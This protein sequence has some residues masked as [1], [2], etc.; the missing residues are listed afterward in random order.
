MAGLTS[1]FRWLL[2]LTL[3]AALVGGGLILRD[4]R[5]LVTQDPPLTAAERTWA[6]RWLASA[7]PR[8]LR[9]GERV[10]LTLSEREANILGNYLIDT[11]GQGRL[12]VQLWSGRARLAVSLG[13]PWNPTTQFM[14]L[15][16]ELVAGGRRPRIERA[17]LAGLPMPDG[18]AQTLADRLIDALDQSRLLQRV[19]LQPDLALLTYEWRRDALVKLGTALV[20]VDEL[21]RILHYQSRLVGYGDAHPKPRTIALADLL[22]L[23]LAEA[24]RQA[25][26]A[27]PAENRAAILALAAYVNHQRVRDPAKPADATPDPAFRSVAL[28]GR[29]DLAQHFMTSATLAAQGGSA[30]SDLLGLY[31]EVSDSRGGSGF[32]FADLAA[33]R[34]GTRFGELATGEIKDA[35]AVQ[36]RARN[37]LREADIMPPIERTARGDERDGLRRRLSRHKK[38]KLPA[39]R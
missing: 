11:L 27:A 3:L 7:K 2:A 9:D 19:D 10:T 24:G 26:A 20:S 22:T 12:R 8:G 13:L 18:L 17:H 4:A 14:N 16:L 28:R 38:P 33:D 35:L 6:L 25:P 1:V 15:D 37:G 23:V 29:H 21:G 36:Q 30:L 34:S 39:R 32:S 5:P 31:K